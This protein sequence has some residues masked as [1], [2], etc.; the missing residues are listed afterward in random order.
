VTT[1]VRGAVT[2][3]PFVRIAREG[4]R[5]L[6][7]ELGRDLFSAYGSYD[8]YLLEW[9]SAPG[10]TTVVSEIDGNG[11]G[12]GMMRF[13]AD[14]KRPTSELVAIAVSASSQ[15]KGAGTSLLLEL[16]DLARRA[17]A[18][19][20]R[21]MVADGNARAERLF[22]RHGFRKTGDAGVYPA[23]QK[24]LVMRKELNPWS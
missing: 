15:R 2:N 19:E 14:S 12:L 10:V 16:F 22:A 5:A 7:A 9:S 24:A 18:E 23:G 1:N 6:I 8:R 11:V 21:L 20:M 13:E 4:D 3:G 17:G